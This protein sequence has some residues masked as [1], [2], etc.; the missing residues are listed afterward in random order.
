MILR[1]LKSWPS[2]IDIRFSYVMKGKVVHL[3]LEQNTEFISI[4]CTLFRLLRI[5]EN[6][7]SNY[8]V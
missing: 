7:F 1:Q 6:T 4:L 2:F 3:N 5:K 8:T